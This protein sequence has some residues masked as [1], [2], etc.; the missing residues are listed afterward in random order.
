MIGGSKEIFLKNLSEALFIGSTHLDKENTIN[1]DG[2]PEKCMCND[3]GNY[4]CLETWTL[5]SIVNDL[6][7]R[8][9]GQ[10]LLQLHT[11][12]TCEQLQDFV[13]KNCI[14]VP[15]LVA[16][17]QVLVHIA[18][19]MALSSR[20]LYEKYKILRVPSFEIPKI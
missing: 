3:R 8:T 17:S 4:L 9:F 6:L 13:N 20:N 15:P 14:E 10:W 12:C 19:G 5:L 18:N 16:N 11:E 2:S 7:V 1:I